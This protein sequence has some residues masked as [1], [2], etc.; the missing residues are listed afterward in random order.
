[1]KSPSRSY[2]LYK[3]PFLQAKAS[4]REGRIKIDVEGLLSILPKIKFA[5][6]MF[7][8]EVPAQAEEK[9]SLSTWI[10][11]VPSLAFDRL[12]SS[13]IKAMLGVR[14]PDQVTISITEECPN[15]CVH[16]ALP[17]SG[18][19]LRLSPQT[20][21][22]IISQILDMGTT[23]VIFDGGE[24]SMYHELPELVKFVDDRAISTIFT[25][26]A[27]FTARLASQLKEAGLY[28]VNVSLDSPIEEEHDLMRGRE[29]VFLDAM[30]AIENALHAGLLV[31]LY[32]VLRRENMHHLRE[33]HELA[34]FKG[35]HELTFFEVVPTGRWSGHKEAALLPEDHDLLDKFVSGSGAPRIFSVPDAYRRFGC[36]AASSWMHI[37]PAGDV[38]PCAC[39]PQSWGSIFEEPV[40]KIWQ[41]MSVFPHKGR[42]KCP[43]RE[44]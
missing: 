10:P 40:R 7:D 27:G 3:S 33:F 36:F 4:L 18:N 31:D 41:R 29:G 42:K 1:M 37:T 24:P 30:Q 35:A 16:C 20:V 23:L 13:R 5:L 38:Y 17:N 15:R 19:K 44:N 25:S 32:V 26:G 22:D 8:G 2:V 6:Q 14:T 39:Y 9:L 43:M 28:A 34:R 11:P 12:A 21:K